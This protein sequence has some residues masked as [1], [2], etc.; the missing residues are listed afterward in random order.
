[1][2]KGELEN[3]GLLKDAI[4]VISNLIS[5]GTFKIKKDG[6]ELLATDPAMVALVNFKLDKKVFKSY[7]ADEEDLSV[8]IESLNS[9]LN[10]A[11]GK[12][13]IR[14][15]TEENRLVLILSNGSKRKFSLPLLKPE[16][17]NLPSI[18]ELGKKFEVVCELKSDALAKFIGDASIVGDAILFK[19][20]NGN[21]ILEVKGENSEASFLLEKGSD[22]LLNIQGEKAKSMF[23]VDYLSKIVKSSKLAEIATIRL[24]NDFPI[25]MEFKVPDALELDF[26]LAPRIEEG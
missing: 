11:E 22:S 3:V 10:R 8:N 18:E 26:V 23:S 24:G 13:K 20:E 1:M 7:E 6:I 2:F 9:I 16:S 19:V 15:E 4:K 12:E 14:I 25:K 5:E 17:E 21:L